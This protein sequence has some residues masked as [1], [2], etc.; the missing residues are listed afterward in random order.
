MFI[1]VRRE[2]CVEQTEGWETGSGK[3]LSAETG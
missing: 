2:W 3:K 1:F